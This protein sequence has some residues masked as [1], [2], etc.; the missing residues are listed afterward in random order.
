MCVMSVCML[1]AENSKLEF[2]YIVVLLLLSLV[3]F[4]KKFKGVYMPGKKS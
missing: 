1:V 3:S 4:N 2:L